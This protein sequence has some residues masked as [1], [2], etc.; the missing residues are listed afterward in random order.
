MKVAKVFLQRSLKPKCYMFDCLCKTSTAACDPSGV[1]LDSYLFVGP[2][3]LRVDGAMALCILAGGLGLRRVPLEGAA[4]LEAFVLHRHSDAQS[5]E[6][7]GVQ[8]GLHARRHAVGALETSS[9][10][11]QGVNAVPEKSSHTEKYMQMPSYSV[12]LLAS[13]NCTFFFE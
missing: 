8:V 5:R 13:I 9:P 11:R 10:A 1:L 6:A 3:S 2:L 12:I 4:K 7:L